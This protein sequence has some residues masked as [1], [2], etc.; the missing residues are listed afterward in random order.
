[1]NWR[2]K[3]AFG[4]DHEYLEALG[5]R[6]EIGIE[7]LLFAGRTLAAP[8]ITAAVGRLGSAAKVMNFSVGKCGCCGS[9]PGLAVLDQDEGHRK[10]YCSLCGSGGKFKRLVCPHCG[11]D[12]TQKLTYIRLGDTD[13]RWIESCDE[14]KRY[15][16]TIDLRKLPA[17]KPLIPIVEETATL[18]LD[19]LAER[20]GY[21]RGL[22][23][24][25]CV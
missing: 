13:P 5:L 18:H 16:K 19:M 2:E 7:A 25:A 11:N 15:I 14:C 17:G 1:M 6:L 20:E 10:L 8:F 22:P 24:T 3:A 23:F 9:S 12:D 4:P 21:L